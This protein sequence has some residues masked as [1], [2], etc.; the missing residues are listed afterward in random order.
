MG[1]QDSV[2]TVERKKKEL[3]KINYGKKLD[4]KHLKLDDKPYLIEEYRSMS[5]AISDEFKEVREKLK[6]I[7]K[8]KAEQE[9]CYMGA[10][11]VGA[12]SIDY[13]K[14]FGFTIPKAWNKT[15]VMFVFEN[16][17][18]N[19]DA[20]FVKD[21]DDAKAA[22]N[23][24]EL[25]KWNKLLCKVIWHADY[26]IQGYKEHK[27]EYGGGEFRHFD[28]PKM[29]SQLLLSIILEFKLANFY[30][31]NMFRYEIFNDV[32]GEE[33]FLNLDKISGL[34]GKDE[35]TLFSLDNDNNS[36]VKE[37]DKFEPK[38]I[39]TTSKPFYYL[40][41]YMENKDKYKDIELVKLPHPAH[42]SLNNTHRFCMNAMSIINGLQK[43]GVITENKR[44]DKII[45]A[46]EK[47]IDLI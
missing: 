35:K 30:T 7:N 18:N 6:K 36:F 15:P 10:I 25:E 12:H 32:D 34:T 29:Y 19:L 37:L 17:S 26:G 5:G 45:E 2:D 9:K 1:K 31:T 21:M 41:K 14:V 40:S 4:D 33:K 28:E 46:M 3:D 13:S 20:C 38:L 16:P 8:G 24:E 44:N 42:P 27:S 11:S 39:F 23:S 22:N 43:A 47:H